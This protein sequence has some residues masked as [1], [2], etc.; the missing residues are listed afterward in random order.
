MTQKREQR[1]EDLI[2]LMESAISPK[3][4]ELLNSSSPENCQNKK[5]T[6]FYSSGGTM[7]A[8]L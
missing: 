4:L 2:T 8:E 7:N 5:Y 6:V 3:T 1:V